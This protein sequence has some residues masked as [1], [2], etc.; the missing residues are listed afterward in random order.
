MNT[1]KDNDLI[2]EIK[3]LLYKRIIQIEKEGPLFD[4]KDSITDSKN[5]R[6]IAAMWFISTINDID[7]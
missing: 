4:T 5:K 3:A 6:I 1:N 7:E 2:L